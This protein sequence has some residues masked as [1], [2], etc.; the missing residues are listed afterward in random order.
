M[1]V[2]GLS[3]KFI[4]TF[5]DNIDTFKFVKYYKKMTDHRTTKK[6]VAQRKKETNS[7]KR[8]KSLN[9]DKT[10][11]LISYKTKYNKKQNT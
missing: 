6:S 9:V 8:T 7:V 5:I 10:K 11:S 3:E 2:F 1:K 4:V